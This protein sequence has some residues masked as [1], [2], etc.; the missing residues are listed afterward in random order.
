MVHYQQCQG[1]Q[2]GLY[3]QNVT[4][5][6][7]FQTAGPFAIKLGLVVQHHMPEHPAEKLDHCIQCQG[8]SE[9]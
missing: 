2:E 5:Y 8:H 9:G 3:N 6:Y 7:I 1:H 4:F